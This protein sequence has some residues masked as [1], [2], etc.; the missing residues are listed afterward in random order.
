MDEKGIEWWMK[1]E[2]KERPWGVRLRTIVAKAL[3]GRAHLSIV[4]N[5]AAL[6]AGTA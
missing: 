5:I 4:A 2:G 3:S 6:V 1:W